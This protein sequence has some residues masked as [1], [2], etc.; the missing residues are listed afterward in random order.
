DALTVGEDDRAD[1]LRTF[2]AVGHVM[3]A[4]PADAIALMTAVDYDRLDD[5]G[6]VV[7]HTVETIAHG[8]VGCATEA[9]LNAMAGYRVQAESPG[10]TIHF[11]GLAE[12]HTYALL[13]AGHLDDAVSV[14]EREYQ[15]CAG[16]PSLS[17]WVALAA[18]GMAAI[19]TGDLPAAV[20]HF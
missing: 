14:A 20:R 17:Q 9:G 3:A 16:I 18:L 7:G 4:E 12:F 6:R 1:S 19:G 10:T 13:A 15:R 2:R 11:T 8:D 5:V